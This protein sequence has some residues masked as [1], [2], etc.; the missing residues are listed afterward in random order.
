MG[1]QNSRKFGKQKV[2]A[3]AKGKQFVKQPQNA[4]NTAQKWWFESQS[5]LNQLIGHAVVSG[6]DHTRNLKL[7]LDF[8]RNGYAEVG[9]CIPIS[10]Y[11]G[12]VKDDG[13]QEPDEKEIAVYPTLTKWLEFFAGD[14]VKRCS[15]ADSPDL[16]AYVASANCWGV[17]AG[18]LVVADGQRPWVKDGGAFVG[19]V[20]HFKV[21]Q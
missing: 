20:L 3:M 18:S 2:I 13:K 1:R 17:T 4:Q 15:R 16:V 7:V 14:D 9:Q 21:V 10:V 11:R 19:T 12:A 6:G 5:E 8:V